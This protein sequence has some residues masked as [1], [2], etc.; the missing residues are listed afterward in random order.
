MF[1]L[2][3]V[4]KK[5]NFNEDKVPFYKLPNPLAYN[6]GDKV[7]NVMDWENKRRLEIFQLFESEVYGKTPDFN[8][9]IEIIETE[10]DTS[11][12]ND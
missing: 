4:Q 3:H 10:V 8:G 9:K 12:L 7:G 6:N 5:T 2:S 1:M 11:A